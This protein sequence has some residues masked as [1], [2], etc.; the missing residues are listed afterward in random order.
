MQVDN[1]AAMLYKLLRRLI[2]LDRQD[3]YKAYF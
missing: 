2:L 1:G 3:P